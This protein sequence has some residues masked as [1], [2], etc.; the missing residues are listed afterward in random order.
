[1]ESILNIVLIV[2]GLFLVVL[3]LCLKA[4]MND[5]DSRPTHH[6]NTKGSHYY[7]SHRSSRS[8]D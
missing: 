4:Q 7:E 3:A 5:I 1:M 2:S 6:D 8:L